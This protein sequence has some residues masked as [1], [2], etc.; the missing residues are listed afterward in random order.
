MRFKHYFLLL[1]KN[2]LSLSFFSPDIIVDLVS[3]N[4]ALHIRLPGSWEII[5]I[6]SQKC[7]DLGLCNW[8]FTT[9]GFS[10]WV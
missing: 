7:S 6:L 8:F 5:Q 9:S 1:L 4:S 2:N 3:L 10:L